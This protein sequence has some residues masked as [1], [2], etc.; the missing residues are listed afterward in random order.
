ME[1]AGFLLGLVYNPENDGS[2]SVNYWITQHCIHDIHS[3]PPVLNIRFLF[4]YLGEET[5]MMFPVY[6]LAIHACL[7]KNI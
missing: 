7:L 3:S 4:L 6:L 1:P 5:F 2:L